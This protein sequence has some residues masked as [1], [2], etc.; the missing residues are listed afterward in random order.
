MKKFQYR[1]APEKKRWWMEKPTFL[2]QHTPLHRRVIVMPKIQKKGPLPDRQRTPSRTVAERLGFEPR[3]HFCTHAFQACSLSRSDTSPKNSRSQIDDRGL[4]SSSRSFSF[5]KKN[6]FSRGGCKQ[7]REKKFD[8]AGMDHWSPEGCPRITPP[9]PQHKAPACPASSSSP[10][11]AS[12][13]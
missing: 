1:T 4:S 2:V 6:S 13:N 12:I 10:S 5:G 11:E 8:A 3:V 9:R 7:A